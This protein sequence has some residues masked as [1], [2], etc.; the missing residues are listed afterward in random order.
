[1]QPTLDEAAIDA[2]LANYNNQ[3]QEKTFYYSFYKVVS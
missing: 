3:G 2:A 1:M